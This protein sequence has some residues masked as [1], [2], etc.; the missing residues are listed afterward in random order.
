MGLL[1]SLLKLSGEADA[2]DSIFRPVLLGSDRRKNEMHRILTI[3]TIQQGIQLNAC[4]FS[5]GMINPFKTIFLFHKDAK[6]LNNACGIPLALQ[7]VFAASRART[8]AAV[9]SPSLVIG[10]R[11][12]FFRCSHHK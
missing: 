11:F 2:F 5:F 6:P 1:F 8:I 9:F 12:L 7:K 10:T 3:S 4:R